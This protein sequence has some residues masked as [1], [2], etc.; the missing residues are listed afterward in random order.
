MIGSLTGIIKNI[1]G[2]KAVLVQAGGV[3]YLVNVTSRTRS[4]LA[5]QAQIEQELFIYTSVKEDALDLYGF[6]SLKERSLFVL[7]VGVSG[8]GPAT[9]LN[10]L[11]H[12]LSE[13]VLAIQE[14][15]VAFFSKIPRLGKKTAQKLIIELGSKLGEVKALEIGPQTQIFQDILDSLVG[16]GFVEAEVV[17]ALKTYDLEAESSDQVVKEVIAQLTKKRQEDNL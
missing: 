5:S 11:E 1:D 15:N 2:S 10:I 17:S 9:A 16:L 8:I 7:I 12:D 3:G 14:A 6:S 4:S 13:I